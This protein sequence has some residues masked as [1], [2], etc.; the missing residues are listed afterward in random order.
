[1]LPKSDPNG[2]N[3]RKIAGLK[4]LGKAFLYSLNDT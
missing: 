4:F 2:R 1:M 3:F